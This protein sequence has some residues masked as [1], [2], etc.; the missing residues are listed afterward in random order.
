MSISGGKIITGGVT[1]A[2]GVKDVPLHLTRSGYIPRLKWIAT[3]YVVLWDEGDKRGWLVNGV[4]ALLHLVRASLEHYARDDFSSSFLFDPEK[5]KETT[6]HKPNSAHKILI[7]DN[8]KSLEIYPGR[9]ETVEEEEIKQKGTD[10]EDSKIRKKKGYFL[11]QDL[12]EQHYSILE[13]IMDHQ[14]LVAG[15]NGVNMKIRGRKHLEGWDFAEL[16]TDH[17]PYPRVATLKAFG[18]GWVDFVRSIDAIT[19]FGKGFG[20]LIRPVEFEGMCP[21]WKGLPKQRYYL[22]ASVFD[23]NNIMRKF[24]DRT[25]SPI[26]PSHDLLWHCPG[27]LVAAC[28]CQNHRN[29]QF[30]KTAFREQSRHHDPVQVFYP[31][32]SRLFLHIR[33]P[34]RLEESGAIVFGHSA[35]WGYHWKE[36][37]E[38]GLGEGEPCILPAVVVQQDTTTTAASI[39]E[40]PE[41]GTSS[42]STSQGVQNRGSTLGSMPHSSPSAYL[43]QFTPLESV[44]DSPWTP[45]RIDVDN[46]PANNPL[47]LS[48][49]SIP[50]EKKARN[51]RRE[52]RRLQSSTSSSSQN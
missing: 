32:K 8:N 17:D 6:E 42:S 4:S 36:D 5:L 50:Q 23:L 11:F 44:I 12:V 43:T 3:K 22:A 10:M 41:V 38:E 48:Q 20:D 1:F 28:Q 24:G 46:E 21:H 40:S 31:R 30:W 29:R 47:G 51:L 19:L 16:A 13:Q 34:D 14:R 49:E 15:Q 37:G 33:S 18:W 26:R 27:D 35:S 45:T 52:T 2:V 25:T 9:I 7:D 39:L